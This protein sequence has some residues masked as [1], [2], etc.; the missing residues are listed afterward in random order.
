MVGCPVDSKRLMKSMSNRMMIEFHKRKP[1]VVPID[2][3]ADME[4]LWCPVDTKRTKPMSNR[5]AI[6]FRRIKI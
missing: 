1:C 4:I 5:M 3:T 6:E 2:L